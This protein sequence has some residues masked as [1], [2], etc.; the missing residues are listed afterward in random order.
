M[1]ES[2]VIP[3]F[4]REVPTGEAVPI[5]EPPSRKR[6]EA[7]VVLATI[8]ELTPG[9]SSRQ[10]L[11][12]V[13]TTF[14][15]IEPAEFAGALIWENFVIGDKE[16]SQAERADTWG[17]TVGGSRFRRMADRASVPFGRM[18]TM[19]A[20]LLK[21][22]IVI[23]VYTTVDPPKQKD[24]SPNPYAGKVRRNIRD[25]YRVGEKTLAARGTDFDAAGNG[26]APAAVA[27]DGDAPTPCPVCSVV[28]AA[29]DFAAHA[30]THG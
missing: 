20:A 15:V 12:Q 23:D 13:A 4:D 24:G 3:E 10:S 1:S 29:K 27:F 17:R 21:R 22:K 2:I 5:Q 16:D 25:F 18:S 30:E 28:T 26:P 11:Y 8:E 6:L 14:R 7:G 9:L 19:V